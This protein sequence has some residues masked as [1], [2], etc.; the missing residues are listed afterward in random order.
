MLMNSDQEVCLIFWFVVNLFACLFFFQDE[1]R[2]QKV[3]DIVSAVVLSI[4]EDCS[5]NFTETNIPNFEFSCRSIENVE[6]IDNTAGMIM[7]ALN[8]F[9][10]SQV[11][12]KY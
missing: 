9:S 8:C 6:P 5:C 3:M 2:S 7:S 12:K 4:Q 10:R 1:N 11:D